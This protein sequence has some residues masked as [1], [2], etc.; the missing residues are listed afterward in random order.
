MDINSCYKVGYILKP[1]GLKGEVTISLDADF[2]ENIDDLK[3]LLV[4][5]NNR[6][7]PHFIES[8]SVRGV[9]AFVRFEDIHSPESASAISK[10]ALYLP[11]TLRPKSGRGE[12]YDDEIIGFEVTDVDIGLLG[13]VVEVTEAGPN[14]LL[15]INYAG[16]EILIPINSPFI[17]SINK[18][19]RKIA[20]ELPEGFL[21]I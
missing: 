3:S 6:L 13:K 11:K 4:E 17:T 20:V 9:K 16:K 12:F 18:A 19:K 14:K 7:I 5:K 8:I 2:P 15:A 10:C 1:H 21:D